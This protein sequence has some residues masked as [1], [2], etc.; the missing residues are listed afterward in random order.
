MAKLYFRY[1]TVGSAKTMNLLAVAHNYRHQNKNVLLLKP[2]LDT[3]FG[4]DVIKSRSGL[5]MDA[6]VLVETDTVLTEDIL[7]E[8]HCI[9]V[10]EAQFLA[11][12]FIDQLREISRHWDIP[13][14]CYG[15][16]TDFKTELF[17]GSQRLLELADS[18]E[19]VKTTCAF[20]NRK[21]IFNVKFVNGIA[22]QSG[23]QVELGAEEKYLPACSYCYYE[24][25][26]ENHLSTP[27]FR[28]PV[29]LD[30]S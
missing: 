14:I 8:I 21:A 25:V 29:D 9:L 4:V 26:S 17:P 12:A 2:K 6:D 24:Q 1:G 5:T 10:D 22:T 23:P 18:I 28:D 20:C 16:R 19:E 7:D 13:V 15:L 30:P 11:K 27:L 3:R